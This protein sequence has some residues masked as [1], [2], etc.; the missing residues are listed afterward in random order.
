MDDYK[1]NDDNIINFFHIENSQEN[2]QTQ[3][4]N[5]NEKEF[6]SIRST[7]QTKEKIPITKQMKFLR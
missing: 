6:E 5:K 3:T 7:N 4:I 2:I 1:N